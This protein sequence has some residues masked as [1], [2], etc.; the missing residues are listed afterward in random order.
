MTDGGKKKNP[1]IFLSL[2]EEQVTNQD[3]YRLNYF[4]KMIEEQSK[5]NNH[6]QTS[7]SEVNSNIQETTEEQKRNYTNLMSKLNKQDHITYHFLDMIKNNETT[8][9][10]LL[11]RLKE[12]EEKSESIIQKVSKDGV[13]NEAILDQLAF[14]DDMLNKLTSNLEEYNR[15]C[16]ELSKNIKNQ[17]EF[18]KELGYKVDLQEVFHKTVMERL[19]EQ[20]ANTK[21]MM[22]QLDHLRSIIYERASFFVNKVEENFNKISKPVQ[23][24]FIQQEEKV[25]KK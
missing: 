5:I 15:S 17:E 18:H 10:A 22:R 12:I 3:Y 25:D 14:Q 2:P 19:D 9:S 11:K 20:E 7:I 16:E 24:F 4:Q 6:I 1:Q 21:K 13:I 23:R 8:Y